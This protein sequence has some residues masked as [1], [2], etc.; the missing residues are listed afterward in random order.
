MADYWNKY[1]VEVRD[2][3]ATYG[4][5]TGVMLLMGISSELGDLWQCAIHEIAGQGS[6]QED[7][8]KTL[9]D[10]L[11]YIAALEIHYSLPSSLYSRY[12]GTPMNLNPK[13][14]F[15]LLSL[16]TDINSELGEVSKNM[17]DKDI[18]ELQF[19]V[20]KFMLSIFNVFTYYNT[21]LLKVLKQSV[22]IMK[23]E[24]IPE[25]VDHN[26]AFIEASKSLAEMQYE[27]VVME[28]KIDNR[29][30]NKYVGIIMNAYGEEYRFE[31][32]DL[33]TDFFCAS[34]LLYDNYGKEPHTLNYGPVFRQYLE[35]DQPLLESG[36]IIGERVMTLDSLIK[37]S[38]L[39]EGVINLDSTARPVL[40]HEGITQLNQL[41]DHVMDTKN[42]KKS[43]KSKK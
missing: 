36:F 18:N 33:M 12:I 41:L 1:K 30:S 7:R 5:Y 8:E 13:H 27:E 40:I 19:T 14:G 43:L 23:E 32:G 25:T 24:L 28:V 6:N 22:D 38:T 21:D 16:Q 42:S 29:R 10:I 31:E 34:N 3:M 11:W 17:K 20:N 26:K 39:E 9:G 2:N 4:D 37:S 15:T 35:E